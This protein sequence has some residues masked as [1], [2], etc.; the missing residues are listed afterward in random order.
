MGELDWE[1]GREVSFLRIHKSDFRCCGVWWVCTIHMAKYSNLPI[2][3]CEFEPLDIPS[4]T[5][6]QVQSTFLCILYGSKPLAQGK[7]SVL[8]VLSYKM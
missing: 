8:I 4:Q 5:L 2:D 7:K 1:R 3:G 6:Y